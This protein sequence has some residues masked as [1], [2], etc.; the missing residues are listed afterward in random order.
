M[1]E[2]INFSVYPYSIAYSDGDWEALAAF[3]RA[4]QLDGIELLIGYGPLPDVPAGLVQGVHFPLWTTWL[5]IWRGVD[6]AAE[7]YFLPSEPYWAAYY[8]GGSSRDE[9][10]VTLH[11]LLMAAAT[12]AP[13]YAVVHVAHVEVPHAWTRAYTYTDGEVIDAFADLLNTTAEACGGEPPVRF[14]LE[15]VWWP[16]LTFNDG[17]AAERLT[18]RL[19]FDNWA[20]VLDTAHLMNTN[21]SLCTEDEA[22]DFVLRAIE[23]LPQPVLDRV[24]GLHL[25]LSLSGSYQLSSIKEGLPEEYDTLSFAEQFDLARNHVSRID[26]HLPF[27][28][29]RCREIVEALAPAFLVHE[30]FTH[31][32]GTDPA[33]Q[34]SIQC[35]ALRQSIVKEDL[36]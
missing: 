31:G 13:Q 17:A 7:R 8:A 4:Q 16:G 20:F 24:E 18:Q 3:V 35:N 32:S 26:Q 30:V 2:L 21:C 33:E 34:V 12:L 6:G 11:E 22:I 28:H 19:Q 15:N 29:P 25:N 14:F 9:M 10:V 36:R 5:D 27:T 23:A 1:K